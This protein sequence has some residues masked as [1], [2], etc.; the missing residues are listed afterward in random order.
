MIELEKCIVKY[1]RYGEGYMSCRLPPWNQESLE[2]NIFYVTTYDQCSNYIWVTLVA[3]IPCINHCSI[4]T[5][6]F[7]I[8]ANWVFGFPH[9]WE[10]CRNHVALDIRCQELTPN[11]IL[12]PTLSHNIAENNFMID[13]VALFWFHS[14]AARRVLRGLVL[15]G[16]GQKTLKTTLIF[17]WTYLIHNI[18]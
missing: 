13:C 14:T 18:D 8:A 10:S 5:R 15:S 12:W 3:H 11:K 4:G 16:H 17:R 2:K 7:C 9:N 1:V 6:A